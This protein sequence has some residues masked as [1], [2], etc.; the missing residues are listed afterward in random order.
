MA[1]HTHFKCLN[2]RIFILIMYAASRNILRQWISLDWSLHSFLGVE[3]QLRNSLHFKL[4]IKCN[5][6]KWDDNKLNFN[7][8]KWTLIPIA[9]T[10]LSWSVSNLNP[11]L[12]CT[13]LT[14]I[15]ANTSNQ[16]TLSKA[17]TKASWTFWTNCVK[18]LSNL[19][20]KNYPKRHFWP[21]KQLSLKAKPPPNKSSWPNC[22]SRVINHLQREA[23]KLSKPS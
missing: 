9:S 15:T 16:W 6:L 21:K 2:I 1:W 12:L 7:F 10:S 23:I 19:K 14:R 20:S 4:S 3:D 5:K 22:K 18:S 8:H 17:T 13:S 11:N